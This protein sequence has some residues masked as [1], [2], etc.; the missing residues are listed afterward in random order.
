MLRK[1]GSAS[2]CI[3]MLFTLTAPVAMAGGGG[4]EFGECD[5]AAVES[6][7]A[8]PFRG[9]ATVQY[10]G[11]GLP[12]LIGINAARQNCTINIPPTNFTLVAADLDLETF[13]QTT[14]SDLRDFCLNVSGFNIYDEGPSCPDLQTRASLGLVVLGPRQLEFNPA[15]T[16]FTVEV[17]L[18]P[19]I[20]P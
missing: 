3:V 7:E 17:T 12:L 16:E 5:S 9:I 19:G 1:Y 18:M 13:R 4:G 11:E 6:F 15:G 8:P 2:L 10:T 14:E 20:L